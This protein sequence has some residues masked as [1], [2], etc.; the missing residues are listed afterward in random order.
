MALYR[1][2]ASSIRWSVAP[3]NLSWPSLK[4]ASR[5]TATVSSNGSRS[6]SV[7][8]ASAW[9]AVVR[10]CLPRPNGPVGLLHGAW[11]PRDRSHRHR[12]SRRHRASPLA[13]GEEPHHGEHQDRSGAH[14]H[15]QAQSRRA[16]DTSG[17]VEI[18]RHRLVWVARVSCS[19]LIRPS[20]NTPQSVESPNTIARMIMRD[21]DCRAP[22][23]LNPRRWLRWP[24]WKAHS[25]PKVAPMVRTFIITA[26]SG[27][28]T[29]RVM[30]KHV[31]RAIKAIS[32]RTRGQVRLVA[33][34]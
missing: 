34:L 30:E 15:R 28:T 11:P 2:A 13:A 19:S 16:D 20:N 29:E 7:H 4:I 1:C 32:P 5:S 22:A 9:I 26:N 33:V 17:A 6:T 25:T 14:G 27:S 23:S 18:E 31:T 21:G 12:A 3:R 8:P 10:S 24:H